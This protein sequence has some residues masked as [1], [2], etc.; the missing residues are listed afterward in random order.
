MIVRNINI[1]KE[2]LNYIEQ[3][4]KLIIIYNKAIHTRLEQRK[5]H[6]ENYFSIK[7]DIIVKNNSEP[8][9]INSQ[10]ERFKVVKCKKADDNINITV[11]LCLNNL[12]NLFFRY[13][14]IKLKLFFDKKYINNIM[15]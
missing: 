2:I 14:Y 10:N 4:R 1:L 11:P 3:Y 13:N 6:Y 8:Y 5:E 7:F 15:N 12:N 9:N